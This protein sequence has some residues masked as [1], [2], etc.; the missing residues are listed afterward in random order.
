VR[1]ERS[2]GQRHDCN[3]S[4]NKKFIAVMALAWR[5]SLPNKT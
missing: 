2:E 5:I 3:T 1:N 4:F